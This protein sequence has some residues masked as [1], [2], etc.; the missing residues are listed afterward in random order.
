MEL[1]CSKCQRKFNASRED[2]TVCPECLKQEF[3]SCAP[4]LEESERAALAAEYAASMKRQAER[5]EAMGSVYAS[6]H[7]FNVAGTI[8][9]SL[10]LGIFFVCAFLFLISDKDTGVTFLANEEIPNQ[11]FFSMIFCGAAALLVATASVYFKKTA[12]TI[13]VAILLMGWF[14]PNMLEMALSKSE[15]TQQIG[16]VSAIQVDPA[17]GKTTGPVLTDADLQV[18]YSLRTASHRLAHYAIY[19]D[20]QD[21][22]SREIVRD[23]LGRLLQAEY[24]RA[25]SRANGA[26]FVCNNVPGERRNISDIL[27]RFGDITYAVPDK[28]VYE[29]SFDPEKANIVSQYSAEVLTSPM[30]SSYVTANLSELRCLDP[31]RVRMSARSLSNSNVQVLRGEIRNTLIEVLNDPWASDPDT[32]AALID[33]MVVYSKDKDKEATAHCLKYFEARRALKR[34]ISQNVTRYLIFQ[35][36]EVM[37]APVIQLWSENPIE[38]SSMLNLL[39]YRVQA[40]LITKLKSSDDI[41]LIGAIL[42]YLEE[43]GTRE[44]LPAIEPFFEYSDSIIRHTARSAAN[45]LRSR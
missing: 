31:L 19:V 33:A 2:V 8:R 36:P 21:S 18:F 30:H 28:G 15:D 41:K 39:G 6:G 1:V 17:T 24:T 42:K 3:S 20:K 37:V 12:Y 34:D 4:R 16:A 38:W 27:R 23:A 45:A 26:L 10:G 13:A 29:V 7:A 32:Y 11:R 9:F 40:P 44:A 5:A 35:N 25:Y 43:H 14:M 22:R